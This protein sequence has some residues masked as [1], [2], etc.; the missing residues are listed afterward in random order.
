MQQEAQMAAICQACIGL[1]FYYR[2]AIN[3]SPIEGSRGKVEKD[4]TLVDVS[5]A[6]DWSLVK[7]WY[8]PS[9]DLGGSSYPTYGF[10]Y[11]GARDA[12]DAGRQMA[13]N[14]TSPAGQPSIPPGGT[15]D[16]WVATD[17]NYLVALEFNGVAEVGGGAT[18]GQ[19]EVTNINDPSLTVSPPA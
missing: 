9:R 5:S 19:L 4:V 18:S 11:N 3:W 13:A 10:I 6:G 15:I 1:G 14:A 16:V 7:V 12:Y 8:D 17:G 2:F